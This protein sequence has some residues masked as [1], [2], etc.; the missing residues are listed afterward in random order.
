MTK[1]TAVISAISAV[2]L[3][4]ASA[5]VLLYW[6]NAQASWASS[7]ASAAVNGVLQWFT[8]AGGWMIALLW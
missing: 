4:V 6:T 3:L 2:Y 5:A 7:T 1:V 8:L